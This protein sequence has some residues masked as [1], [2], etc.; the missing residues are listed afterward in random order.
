MHG[1]ALI[2]LRLHSQW[3]TRFRLQFAQISDYGYLSEPKFQV[4]IPFC[5][6]SLRPT[7]RSRKIGSQRTF[8]T[9][10]FSGPVQVR[11][12]AGAGAYDRSPLDSQQS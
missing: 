7:S 8:L 3:Q 10:F 2:F 6:R 4:S 11:R 9:W 1:L 5:N 12:L